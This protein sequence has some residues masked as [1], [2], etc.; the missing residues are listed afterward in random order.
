[1]QRRLKHSDIVLCITPIW[2]EE[3]V[4]GKVEHVECW[5]WR[6]FDDYITVQRCDTKEEVDVPKTN[7]YRAY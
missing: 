2:Y 1:M 6:V 4:D 5:V 7:L 3:V